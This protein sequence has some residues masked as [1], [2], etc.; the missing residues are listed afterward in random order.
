MESFLYEK[1]VSA[2]QLQ[3]GGG[4][5][6]S[7]RRQEKQPVVV[8]NHVRVERQHHVSEV[9]PGKCPGVWQ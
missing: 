2:G 8:G 1:S 7:C 3:C 6:R 9:C 5:M 4:R